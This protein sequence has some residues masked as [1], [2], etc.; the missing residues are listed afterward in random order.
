MRW[1]FDYF[2][3]KELNNLITSLHLQINS[4]QYARV[5]WRPIDLCHTQ[6]A[7][8]RNI[9]SLL[10]SARLIFGKLFRSLQST[11]IRRMTMNYQ[12]TMAYI[13]RIR[14]SG[15]GFRRAK[16]EIQLPKCSKSGKNWNFKYEVRII[17]M[18]SI[19]D[20]E[21][22]WCHDVRLGFCS[23]LHVSFLSFRISNKFTYKFKWFWPISRDWGKRTNSNLTWVSRNGSSKSSKVTSAQILELTS[24]SG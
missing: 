11:Q 20:F 15:S 19:R 23:K 13:L 7:G 1:C 8:G 18:T 4:A 6:W 22:F 2:L 9:L 14:S 3:K 5:R 10:L 21:T 24:Y 12:V 16:S 17:A